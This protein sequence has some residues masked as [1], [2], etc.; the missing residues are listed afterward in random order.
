MILLSTWET[1]LATSIFGLINGGPA[2]LIYVYIACAIG[3]AAV[4][5]SMA[6]MGSMW[7]PGK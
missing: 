2:G 1:Q 3:F 4:V 7:V 6:E 5:L